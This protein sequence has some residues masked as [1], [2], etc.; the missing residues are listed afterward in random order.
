MCVHMHT[1]LYAHSQ[2]HT[3]TPKPG[4]GH[5]SVV[6]HVTSC[7]DAGLIPSKIKWQVAQH[8]LHLFHFDSQQLATGAG[9]LL[10]YL[11]KVMMTSE[12]KPLSSGPTT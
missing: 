3:E 10:R 7:E 2:T 6:E 4:L 1:C 8:R 9:V 12:V 11:I 5:T